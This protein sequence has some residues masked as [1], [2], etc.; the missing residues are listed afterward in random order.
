MLKRIL[1]DRGTQVR[2][3]RFLLVGGISYL[4]Q[5]TGI[6]LFLGWLGANL[7]FTLSFIFSTSAHYTLNRLWALPSIRRDTLRQLSEYLGVAALSYAINFS[8]FRLGL[9]LLGFSGIWAAALAVPPSTIMVFL[10]LNGRVFR[11]GD[12]VGKG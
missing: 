3:L 9:D 11:H 7:A 4:V 5:I 8:L 1:T 6:R 2:F 10:L 12:Q